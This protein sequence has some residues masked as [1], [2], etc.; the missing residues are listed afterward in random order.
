MKQHSR[1]AKHPEILSE[2]A[3]QKNKRPSRD[4]QQQNAKTIEWPRH[5]CRSFFK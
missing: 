4:K 3:G 5:E 2:K 1:A